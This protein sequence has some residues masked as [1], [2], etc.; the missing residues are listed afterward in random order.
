MIKKSTKMSKRTSTIFR[1]RDVI[2]TGTVSLAMKRKYAGVKNMSKSSVIQTQPSS[3][4]TPA[5]PQITT[6]T[7]PKGLE[8]S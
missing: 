2:L 4:S 5:M 8:H 3:H 6:V 1:I 7:I